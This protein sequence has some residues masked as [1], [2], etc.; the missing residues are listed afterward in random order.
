MIQPE[1]FQPWVD[2]WQL[3]PDGVPFESL[4]GRLMAVRRSGEAAMLKLSQ[5]PE[6]IAG[7]ALMSWWSGDGAAR[8]LAREGEALLL[9]RAMGQGDLASMARG[10]RDVEA[11]H[12]LCAAGARLHAPRPMPPP[13]TLVPLEPWFRQLWPTATA[14][15][16]ILAKSAS[17]ARALLDVPQEVT[18]LHGDLHHGNVLDF[19]P[20]GWLAIDPKGLIGDRGYDHANMLCNPD[21]ETAL[22]AGVMD[23]RIEIVS[24]AA[25]MPPARLLSWL[26][27]YCG[28]SASW[29]MAEGPGD[30]TATLQ[31]AEAAA[32]RLGL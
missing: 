32:S 23:R 18:V 16:G 1:D 8:V 20:K 19:G 25:N 9:E 24:A 12:I 5:T 17:V 3:S 11:C 26:L 7:G 22:A 4:A 28:L 29:S 31:I 14:H 30:A 13:E 10:G 21:A 15:G 2:R 27:A 6:E